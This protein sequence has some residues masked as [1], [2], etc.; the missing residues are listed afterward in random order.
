MT[1]PRTSRTVGGPLLVLALVALFGCSSGEPVEEQVAAEAKSVL[2]E[3]PTAEAVVAKLAMADMADGTADQV[4]TLCASCKLGMEGNPDHAVEVHG[5]MMHF[6]SEG[7]R[8]S[9]EAD[10]DEA[11]LAL[12]IA[13]EPAETAPPAEGDPEG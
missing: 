6:C 8:E 2:D 13:E 3:A 7:C 5:Y 1:K 4:V 9:F 11:I 10:P 12:V